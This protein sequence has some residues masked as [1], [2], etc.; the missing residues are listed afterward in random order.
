MVMLRV[1]TRTGCPMSVLSTDDFPA[2]CTARAEV[3][4]CW[5]WWRHNYLD[6]KTPSVID[7]LQ[8]RNLGIETDA[9]VACLLSQQNTA[10]SQP[11]LVYNLKTIYFT[12]WYRSSMSSSHRISISHHCSDRHNLQKVGRSSRSLSRN[13]IG[14]ERRGITNGLCERD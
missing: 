13:T 10:Q 1:D 9:K 11:P 12:I 7:Q 8:S 5:S 14:Q 6:L 3:R 2:P 4:I